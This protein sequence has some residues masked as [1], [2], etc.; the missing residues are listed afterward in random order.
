VVEAPGLGDDIQAI[1]AGITEIADIFA[2]NKA[3]REGADST[4]MAL[5]MT[6]NLDH[7]SHLS[8]PEPKWRPPICK[9]IALRSEGIEALAEAIEEHRFYLQESGEIERRER[10]RIEG[11][12]RSIITQEM[13]RSFFERVDEAQLDSLIDGI[14]R[15][16][17]DPYSAAAVLLEGWR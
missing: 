11:E 14:M 5:E 9:T 10:E 6:L 4:A 12:L 1:K 2:V 3:D 16:E 17:L 13:V 7:L 15:R 8:S